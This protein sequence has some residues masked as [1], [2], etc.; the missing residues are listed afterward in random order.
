MK[1][2]DKP[3]FHFNR[4]LGLSAV[5]ARRVFLQ[6]NNIYR[7]MK[8]QTPRDRVYLSYQSLH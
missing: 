7:D 1:E 3:H 2:Q 5:K 4:S 6:G 8:L